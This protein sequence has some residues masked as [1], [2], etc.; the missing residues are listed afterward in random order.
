MMVFIHPASVSS[1]YVAKYKIN[2]GCF[3]DW[4]LQDELNLLRPVSVHTA[5]EVCH[6]QAKA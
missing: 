3:P 6:R 4:G 1:E 5:R 2:V